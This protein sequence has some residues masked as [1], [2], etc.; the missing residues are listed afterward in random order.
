[1]LL[2]WAHMA[3][4]TWL[5]CEVLRR[6][7]DRHVPMTIEQAWRG[8]IRCSIWM[9]ILWRVISG[10]HLN[11]ILLLLALCHNIEGRC[12][13]GL[14]PRLS[15]LSH[16]RACCCAACDCCLRAG[17]RLLGPA[18]AAGMVRTVQ[19]TAGHSCAATAFSLCLLGITP[20]AAQPQVRAGA[21]CWQGG[22][23]V[24]MCRMCGS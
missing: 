6:A 19:L 11:A 2:G 17:C 15:C 14:Q 4:S 21:A 5:Q 13:M 7:N 8:S 16:C 24:G 23:L 1:M 22:L 12:V 10:H 9:A 18:P 3:D 20:P